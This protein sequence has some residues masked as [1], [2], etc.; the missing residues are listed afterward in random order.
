MDVSDFKHLERL[1]KRNTYGRD[2]NMLNWSSWLR[3][4]H[5]DP[6]WMQRV[7]K[8][9]CWHGLDFSSWDQLENWDSKAIVKILDTTEISINT[10]AESVAN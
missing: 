8:E 5:Q 7:L 10:V 6:G 2:Q 1:K 3:M 4:H 9:D